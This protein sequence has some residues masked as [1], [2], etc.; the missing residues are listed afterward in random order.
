MQT[1]ALIFVFSATVPQVLPLVSNNS[2]SKG[3]DYEAHA[4]PKVVQGMR[5]LETEMEQAAREMEWGS[6]LRE[7]VKRTGYIA[8]PLVAVSLS[9]YFLQIISTMMVGHLGELYLSC[10]SLAI[11][12]RAVTG[13]SF[14][15]GFSSGLETLCGQ[16]YG[17][18]QY[19]Q[20]GTQILA[21]IP[22]LIVLS[23]PL[24]LLWL[25]L[26]KILTFVGQDPKISAEAGRFAVHLIPGPLCIRSPSS[27]DQILPDPESGLPNG[28]ELIH[29]TY[30]PRAD[31]LD[32]CV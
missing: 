3:V 30:L 13:F 18:R 27:A 1:D 21:G 28:H 31:Q 5:S 14:I 22:S 29:H 16:S 8:A 32:A 6:G 2:L 7:E 17:A 23:L 26:E 12:F 19:H 10:T 11:S 4:G 24:S 20:F 25:Y 15:F 9:L